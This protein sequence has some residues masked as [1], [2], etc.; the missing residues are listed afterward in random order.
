MGAA[1]GL[2]AALLVMQASQWLKKMVANF[3]VL[4]VSYR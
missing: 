1:P 2:D 3:T 4:K